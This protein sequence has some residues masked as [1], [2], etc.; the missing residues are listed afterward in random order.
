M[1]GEGVTDVSG[2]TGPAGEP[3]AA[4][5]PT[6]T[7]PAELGRIA[8]FWIRVLADTLDAA[9]LW[10]V[11]FLLS[12]P[13]RG[14]FLRLGERGVFVGLAISLLYTGVLQSRLGGGRT[15]GKRL[16]GLTVVRP[17]GALLSLDRSLVRYALMGLLVYQGAVA[18]T[19]ALL[20]PF[21]S[22]SLAQTLMGSIAVALF[23][24]CVLVV[25]FH[26]LKR[27]LHDLLAGTIVIRG[28]MP[29]P[30]YIAARMNPRRDRR[31]VGGAVALAVAAVLG[32]TFV[33]RRLSQNSS[34]A[35]ALSFMDQMESVGISQPGIN[36]TSA[37]F[38][39][40]TP[41]V[42][43]MASG[44]VRQP[45]GGGEPNLRALHTAAIKGMRDL[46]AA[47]PAGASIDRIGTA[48]TT[49]FNLGIYK[50]LETQVVIEDARTG[51]IVQTATNTNW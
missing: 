1:D 40:G 28:A 48:L 26:P 22:V 2:A 16:L 43:V 20:V 21:L 39:F 4:P 47:Q 9:F 35:Q 23:F 41:T 29:D 37:S 14:V 8:G 38:N 17:D 27:G 25:P 32:G 10:F 11:G 42:S 5:A 3:A 18:A 36:I 45:A 24:G 34:V 44:F 7:T 19:L 31:I 30:A 33:V 50:S 51:E 49:G 15:L 12:L 6:T 46:I 13:L